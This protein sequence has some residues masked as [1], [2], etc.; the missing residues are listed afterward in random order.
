LI[1]II[2]QIRI[3]DMIST[4]IIYSSHMVAFTAMTPL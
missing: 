4:M 3:V 2:I 1:T